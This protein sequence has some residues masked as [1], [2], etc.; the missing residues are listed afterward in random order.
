MIKIEAYYRQS[1]DAFNQMI[2]VNDK[3]DY[4]IDYGNIAKTRY[5]GADVSGNIDVCKWFSISP[6]V[7]VYG[8]KYY[9]GNISYDIPDLPVSMDARATLNFKPDKTTRI[10]VNGFVNAPYYDVQGWQDYF[11]S[12]GV[13]ARK[14][15]LK[16]LT[17]VVSINNLFGLYQYNSK[18]RDKNLYNTFHI[19]SEPN[20]AVFSL[21]Y[22]LNN[23]KPI[24]RNDEP[25]DLNIN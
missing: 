16:R 22:K 1:N 2:H 10:Q 15:L 18:N 8:Y 12:M 5:F 4:Y 6:A 19:W 11:Y 9:S 14:E 17:A 23:Y 25:V 13:S 3:G 24:R 7:S 20:V 21:S